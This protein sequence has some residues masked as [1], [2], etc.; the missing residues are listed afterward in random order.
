MF[1]I[2]VIIPTY[3]SNENL[4]K[5]IDSIKNQTIGFE[6]IEII[7]VDDNSDDLRVVKGLIG[8]EIIY[9]DK[10]HNFPGYARNH[11]LKIATGEYVIFADHDDSYVCDAFEVLYNEIVKNN[12]DFVFSNYYKVQ[13]EEYIK[14]NTVFNGSKVV[15]DDISK[16]LNLLTLSPSIWTKLF[17]REFLISNNIY[18]LENMLGEDLYVFIKSLLNSSKTVYLDDF[19]SYNYSIRDTSKDKSTIHLRNKKI[20]SNMIKGYYEVASLLNDEYF[21]I[22]FQNHFVYWLTSLIKS[23]LS[24]DDKIDLLKMINPLFVRYLSINS[25][26]SEKT[27]NSLVKPILNQN[28]NKIIKKMALI[29]IKFKIKAL[30]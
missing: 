1:K 9:L 26:F 20:F 2:S 29:K 24:K 10:N 13:N 28:Y 15:I 5:L 23:D 6:N 7:I 22:V 18:F 17:K 19:A 4:I 25:D 30:I 8:C 21:S 3:N 14:V 11:G 12:A 16:E 27:Y